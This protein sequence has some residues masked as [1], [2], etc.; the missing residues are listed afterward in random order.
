M[1]LGRFVVSVIKTS[2]YF[3]GMSFELYLRKENG[4]RY[5]KSS[6]II[7]TYRKRW[8]ESMCVFSLTPESLQ[9]IDPLILGLGSRQPKTL[10]TENICF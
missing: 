10:R 1:C 5:V 2:S 6:V 9:F 8:E 3:F 4:T 7:K